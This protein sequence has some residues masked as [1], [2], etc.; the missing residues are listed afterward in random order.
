M[1]IPR[2]GLLKKGAVLATAILLPKATTLHAT[3]PKPGPSPEIARVEA[4]LIAYFTRKG[5]RQIAPAPLVTDDHGFNGGLRYDDSDVRVMP[6]TFFIQPAA[7]TSDIAQRH[8]GDVLPIFHIFRLDGK[9]GEGRNDAFTI[10]MG[11]LE[12]SLNLDPA[13]L[14]FVSIPSFEGM[15]PQIERAGFDHDRQVYI[16]DP[17]EALQAGDGS[18]FF[19]HPGNRTYPAYPTAGV[20]YWVGDGAAPSVK[21]YPMPAGWTELGELFIAENGIASFALGVE[22]LAYAATGRIPPWD[23]ELSRLMAHIDHASAPGAPPPGKAMFQ[24]P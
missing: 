1:I 2:R 20:Y 7:R 10:L 21:L 14:A 12:G 9:R 17:G 8:R 6:G 16:R 11:Y 23:A 5:Y 22:R 3:T 4:T 15:R 19:K 13:R 24:Q 18:G